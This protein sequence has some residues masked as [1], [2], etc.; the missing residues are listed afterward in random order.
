MADFCVY[1]GALHGQLPAPPSKSAAHRALI[2]AALAD[3][4]SVVAP[5]ASSEDM[6]ATT[7]VLRSM[8]TEIDFTADGSAKITSGCR[9]QDKMVLLDCRESGSTLRF[10]LPVACALGLTAT[11]AGRGRLPERP[12][13]PLMRALK[14]HGI[15]F[16]GEKMPF[17]VRGCLTPGR[18]ELPGDVSSQFVSGLLFALPLLDEASEIVLTSPLQSAGYVDMTLAAL[19]ASGITVEPTENGWKIP[20]GQHYRPG[21]RAVEADWSNAAFWLCA[22][23]AGGEV[24]L[25]GLSSVSTQGDRAIVEILKRFGADISADAHAIQCK[26][27][28]L[29]GIRIDAGPIPDL[30]PVLAVT[31]A[32]AEGETEIYNAARL[33]IKESDRL[34]SVTALLRGLG[35]TVEEFPDRLVIHG[36]KLHGG[37]VDGMN[38]HRIVMSA[39]VAALGCEAPVIIRDAGAIAKSYPDFFDD[40]QKLGGGCDVVQLGKKL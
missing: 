5:L 13:G 14:A 8:G 34:T 25:T 11:I 20:G 31:A 32:F 3:G 12:L 26:A 18:Y 17:I 10:L 2:C 15:S 21:D 19:G 23:A 4:N 28:K 16:S 40:F 38:D 29:R 30:I 37:I 39:A 33:R 22:G 36:G 9:P 24:R 1:P 7:G 6:A 35:G 27:A